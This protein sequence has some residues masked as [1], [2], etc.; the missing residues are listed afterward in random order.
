[1]KKRV[2]NSPKTAENRRSGYSGIFEM[3]TKAEKRA[4]LHSRA[5]DLARE[6]ECRE[7]AG[8]CLDVL[9]FLLT[10]ETYAIETRSI[11]EV[12]P[13]IELTPLPVRRTIYSASSI[14]VVRF[15]QSLT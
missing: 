15:S 8:E 3:T 12:H 10:H 13:L 7:E 4:I 6:S 5:K 14:S 9:V 2:T 11:R 1:M